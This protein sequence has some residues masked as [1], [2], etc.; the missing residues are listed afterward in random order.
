MTDKRPYLPCPMPGC[1]GHMRIPLEM[2]AAMPTPGVCGCGRAE[3]AVIPDAEGKPKLARLNPVNVLRKGDH[4]LVRHTYT[5][6]DDGGG[7][8]HSVETVGRG[9]KKPR[10]ADGSPIDVN[11][12]VGV[13][14]G[15]LEP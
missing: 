13:L 14:P 1:Y 10:Y 4:I 5:G 15:V 9:G 11:S 6:V 3:I 12:V 2:V 8:W 7:E